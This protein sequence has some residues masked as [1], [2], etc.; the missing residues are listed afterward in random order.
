MF[1]K[2]LFWVLTAIILGVVLGPLLWI[3]LSAFKSEVDIFQGG[4]ALLLAF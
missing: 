3:Y 4:I 2:I 1:K